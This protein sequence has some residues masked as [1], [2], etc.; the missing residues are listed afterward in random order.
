VPNVADVLS[1]HWKRRNRFH[2]LS[3]ALKDTAM[4]FSRGA[5]GDIAASFRAGLQKIIT[6]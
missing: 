3:G 4:S 1:A 5:L 6:N 2:R